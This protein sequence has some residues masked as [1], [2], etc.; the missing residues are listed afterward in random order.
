V[1]SAVNA[2]MRVDHPNIWGTVPV[3]FQKQRAE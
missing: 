3:C 1:S 2:I